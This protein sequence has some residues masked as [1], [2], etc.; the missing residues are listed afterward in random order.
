MR[1][2]L[3]TNAP[4]VALRVRQLGRQAVF[5][6]AVSL[7]RAAKDGQEAIREEMRRAF[8][9]PTAYTLNGTFI[10]GATKDRLESRIWVKDSVGGRGVSPNRYL[11]P[12]I[13][14]GARGQKG[15]DKLLVA[16]GF[17]SAGW[18]AVPA[19]GAQLDA[20]GNVKRSQILQV[21]AQLRLQRT[22]GAEARPGPGARATRAAS[23][24]GISYFALA[25]PWRGLKPGI[26]LQRRFA[27]GTAVRPVF[28]FVPRVQY[29]A[30]LRFFEVGQAAMERRFRYHFDIELAK[31]VASARLGGAR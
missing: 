13:Q 24:Q 19:A 25:A 18:F 30:R 17:M 10:K 23:K 15:L 21:I 7:T 14:G 9:G 6:A 11:L 1:L 12:E 4:D 26:Y 28:I 20:N 31:A 8:V 16:N 2:N 27:H 29:K 3:Q 5:A 22:D